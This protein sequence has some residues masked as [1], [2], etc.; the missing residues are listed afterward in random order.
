MQ[1]VFLG[2]KARGWYIV[3]KIMPVFDRVPGHYNFLF[4]HP[5]AHAARGM[6]GQ[7]EDM[8]PRG[9]L[10]SVPNRVEAGVQS[11]DMGQRDKGV[12]GLIKTS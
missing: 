10:L 8:H 3:Y 7:E 2:A 6:A 4:R 9:Y 1:G 12:L 5:Q 11:L